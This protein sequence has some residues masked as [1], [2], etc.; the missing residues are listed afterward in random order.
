MVDIKISRTENDLIV[1]RANVL[2]GHVTANYEKYSS[3]A[4]VEQNLKDLF[5]ELIERYGLNL[6]INIHDER[7]D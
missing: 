4:Y 5:S 6:S 1:V 7:V 3:T 2:M